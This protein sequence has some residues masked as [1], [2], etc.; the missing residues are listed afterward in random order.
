MKNIFP[1]RLSLWPNLLDSLK[2]FLPV[3]AP[4]WR[5]FDGIAPSPRIEFTLLKTAQDTSENWQ[6]FRPRPARLSFGRMLGR[7]F[8]NPGWNEY[9][10]LGS[11]AERFAESPS[12]HVSREILN[13]IADWLEC[14]SANLSATPCLKFRL[15]FVS[16]DGTQLQKNITFVSPAINLTEGTEPWI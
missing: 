2:L 12:P 15:V 11:C 10:F 13:R 3:L 7:M 14:N 1:L 6:E 16:R 5:F 4:S 9:L 8:W